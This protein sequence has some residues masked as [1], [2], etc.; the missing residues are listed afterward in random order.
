[1][2]QEA[3]VNQSLFLLSLSRPSARF[4]FNRY[5]F[6][7][8][9]SVPPFRYPDDSYDRLWQRYGRNAAWTNINTT[10]EQ[11]DNDLTPAT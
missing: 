6:N 11:A 5:Q 8:D 7:P 10:K 4:D 9:Y 3:S 2:Y 1:M